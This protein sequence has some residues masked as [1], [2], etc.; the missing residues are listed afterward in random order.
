MARFAH[1]IKTLYLYI[2]GSRLVNVRLDEARVHKARRLRET[3]VALSDVVREAIDQRFA[4]L[5]RPLT[6]REATARLKRILEAHRDPSD[7]PVRSYDVHDRAASRAAIVSRL[8]R[9]PR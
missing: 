5:D 8:R 6:T 3:G 7:L 9:R 1:N 2:M 4:A